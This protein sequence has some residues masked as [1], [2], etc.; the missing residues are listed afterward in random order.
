MS[1]LVDLL[2]GPLISRGWP[3]GQL[4]C[5]TCV[6]GGQRSRVCLSSKEYSSYSR[7][8][9]NQSILNSIAFSPARSIV[10]IAPGARNHRLL[11]QRNSFAILTQGIVGAKVAG[12]ETNDLS[13]HPNTISQ[14]PL[15]C[16]CV[17]HRLCNYRLAQSSHSNCDNQR[18]TATKYRCERVRRFGT[19]KQPMD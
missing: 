16:R 4:C 7:L 2:F 6:V 10:V 3:F 1:L 11:A 9:L 13:T 19:I 12:V 8:L 14:P 18:V 15:C 5:C 17:L